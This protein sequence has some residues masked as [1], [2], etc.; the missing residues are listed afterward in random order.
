MRLS[1]TILILFLAL[2]IFSCDTASNVDPLYKDYFI[3]T[4]GTDGDQVG[5]DFI[6]NSDNTL[7]ILGNTT[8]PSG[9]RKIYFLKTTLAGKVLVERILGTT[10]EL[11]MDIE[12]LS[13]GYL[14]LSNMQSPS[15]RF[16]T[17]NDVKLTKV[18]FEGEE[19]SSV[20]YNSLD[21]QFGNSVTSLNDGR[22]FVIGNTRDID[23]KLNGEIVNDEE[24]VLIIEFDNTL[25]S[26]A[27]YRIG[28]STIAKGIKIYD[29]GNST[30]TYGGYSNELR[31][32]NS[33]NLNLTFRTFSTGPNIV[34]T[35]IVGDNLSNERMSSF[36]QISNGNF[37]GIG[38]EITPSGSSRLFIANVANGS[39]DGPVKLFETSIGNSKLEGVTGCLSARNGSLVV[40]ANEFSAVDDK[41]SIRLYNLNPFDGLEKWSVKIGA[42]GYDSKAA[43]VTTLQDGSIIILGT[44]NL[45]NQ[46]KIALI[47]LNENGKFE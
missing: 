27:S 37:Y 1:G 35:L 36:I 8:L 44:V 19:L 32:G 17:R 31:E 14:I 25:T 11:A 34:P 2:G 22:F 28:S 6:L 13:D 47:K 9:E 46:N 24:D 40:V 26:I 4:F 10:T 30:Y 18:S 42:N 29:N 16:G 45:I 7:T 3:K 21:D 5:V 12:P 39:N 23:D 20:I 38:T 15:T 43:A 41:S 33:Y